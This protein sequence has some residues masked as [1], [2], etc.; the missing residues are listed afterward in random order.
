MVVTVRKTPCSKNRLLNG[1]KRN[2]KVKYTC[3]RQ[4]FQHLCQLTTE[5]FKS[6]SLVDDHVW[7]LKS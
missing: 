4:L 3:M 7:S 6:E 2:S 1:M 5:Q